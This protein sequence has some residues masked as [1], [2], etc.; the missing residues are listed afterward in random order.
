MNSSS[1]GPLTL[2]IGD[3]V[4]PHPLSLAANEWKDDM[5]LWPSLQENHITY[6]LLKTKA[7]DLEDVQAIKSLDSYNYVIS[8][9][10]GQLLVCQADKGTCFIKGK[11]SPSQADSDRPY[12]TWVC[13][14]NDCRIWTGSC[15]CKVGLTTVCS[16]VGAVLW[17]I[18]FASRKGL[19]G[20]SCT[21]RSAKWNQGTKRN[22]TPAQ[23]DAMDFRLRKEFNDLQ[24]EGKKLTT[25]RYETHEQ[26]VG[27]MQQSTIAPLLDI[28]GSL[29]HQAVTA[30]ISTSVHA[31][32]NLTETVPKLTHGSH[33]DEDDLLVCETC[34]DF[35]SKWVNIKEPVRLRLMEL[36]RQQTGKLW[37]A[38]RKLRLTASNV[39]KVPRK[40]DTPPDNFVKSCLFSQF[41]GN[42]ATSHGQRF[43]PVARRMFENQNGV[44]VE[45]CG[46]VVSA[47]HPFL[48]AS[49]DGLVGTQS[50]LEIKCP[51]VDDCLQLVDSNKYDLK[52]DSNGA[53]YLD[54]KGKNGYY[55]QVQF[56][57]FC[58]ERTHCYFYVWSAMNSVLVE[59][60]FDADFVCL[61]I[62]RLSE[63]Y[64]RQYL[65]RLVNA[66]HSNSLD[67]SE[68]K[69]A[70]LAK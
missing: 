66:V 23:I 18:E 6:Y 47:T 52:K 41:R 54:K 48:S 1:S 30:K 36:T 21:D 39:S 44:H 67:I 61:H 43:E 16:H 45:R 33:E 69:D 27:E 59:V 68:Y 51:I 15:S 49:P 60:P 57:M 42:K 9:K 2:K 5:K 50:I 8:G 56:V 4:L 22:V 24:H 12:E 28:K 26:Y 53:Y 11:V 62:S 17:K 31:K 29:L 65:P 14:G 58:T 19:T 46:T 25:K 13:I 70:V 34:S 55:Y 20:E 64:F 7:C 40:K 63:F 35:Y 10:V 38:S 37:E 32:N 3:R